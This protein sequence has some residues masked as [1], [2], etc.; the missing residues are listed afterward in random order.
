MHIDIHV[1]IFKYLQI[2]FSRQA[3]LPIFSQQTFLPIFHIWNFT[4]GTSLGRGLL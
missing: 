4:G 2:T 3:F 1:Y